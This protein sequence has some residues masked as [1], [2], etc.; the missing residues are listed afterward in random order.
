MLHSLLYSMEELTI[1]WALWMQRSMLWI[2]V[3][4]NSHCSVSCCS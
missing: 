4:Y 1:S 3:G 2:T